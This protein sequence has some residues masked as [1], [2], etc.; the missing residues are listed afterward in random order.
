M[1]IIRDYLVELAKY[2]PEFL[3]QDQEM[4]AILEAESREHRVQVE[5]LK[6]L[7]N[8]LFVDS[9]TWGLSNFER[10]LGLQPEADDDFVQR[11]NRILLYLQQK[12]TVNKEFMEALFRRYVS[13]DSTIKVVEDNPENTFWVIDT[14][15]QILYP[16]D[17]FDA[18]ETY[19]P[20]HLRFGLQ[21]ERD[22]S[23]SDE[24]M[25]RFAFSYLSEGKAT[26]GVKPPE[27]MIIE[28]NPWIFAGSAGRRTVG[29]G[30]SELS[31]RLI[32]QSV[33]AHAHVGASEI[34]ADLNDLPEWFRSITQPS[35]ILRMIG[36]ANATSGH[37]TLPLGMP[38]AGKIS[39]LQ[40][41]ITEKT[42][43]RLYGLAPPD[44][45]ATNVRIGHLEAV[46]GRLEVQANFD[47]FAQWIERVTEPSK[48]VL[49]IKLKTEAKGKKTVSPQRPQD[50]SND[51]MLGNAHIKTG[52]VLVKANAEDILPR[53]RAARAHV[54]IMQA[55]LSA[56][57]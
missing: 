56:V 37:R 16:K 15:G 47:D 20:A 10:N 34:N 49:H 42:G 33:I 26:I 11:R 38:D 7:V 53:P 44:N 1:N 52:R 30:V 19:K 51:M 12:R 9:A 21:I 22:V 36:T 57:G 8:Q 5:I 32:W 43:A 18:I 40:T 41:I 48:S 23:I 6:D 54:G 35:R 28:P 46:T 3:R 29:A 24:D 45:A 31:A 4:S 55:G 13:E 17:L 50:A 27:P 39:L 2:L 25:L 14:G